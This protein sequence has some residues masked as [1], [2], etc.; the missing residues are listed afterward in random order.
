MN[1]VFL[2][3][4]V[5]ISN[6]GVVAVGL[7]TFGQQRHVGIIYRSGKELRS[8]HLGNHHDLRDD[9]T[10]WTFW[11][12]PRIPTLRLRQVAAKCRQV[13]HANGQ[14]IPYAFSAPNG[15]FSEKTGEY[16]LGPTNLG[17]TC[18]TFV[19]AVFAAVGVHLLNYSDWPVRAD[20]V[21]WQTNVLRGLAAQPGVSPDH[22]QAVRNQVGFVRVRPTE[23]GAAAAILPPPGT[24]DVIIKL[25]SEIDGRFDELARAAASAT[26]P[27]S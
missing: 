19:L 17:L 11:I 13:A 9:E 12:S 16:L 15:C 26:R 25:G 2:A 22:L 14:F 23:V 3:D 27:F 4:E 8:L 24:P 10:S 18:A 20:D 6:V 5:S 7:K 1:R 21:E